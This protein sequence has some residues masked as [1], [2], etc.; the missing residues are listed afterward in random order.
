MAAIATTYHKN[1]TKV[2]LLFHFTIIYTRFFTIRYL[3]KLTIA[4]K[5]YLCHSKYIN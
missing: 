4:K 3:D 5:R 1:T 2:G